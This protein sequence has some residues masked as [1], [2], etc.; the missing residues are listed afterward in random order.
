MINAAEGEVF[1]RINDREW[2]RATT[3]IELR[4]GDA[5]KTGPISRAELLLYPG[6]YLRLSENTEV[7]FTDTSVTNLKLRIVKGTAIIEVAVNDRWGYIESVY[8]LITVTT[9]KSE[10]AIL[11][12][13]IYRFSIEADGRGEVSVRKGRV[14]VE[15]ILVREGKKAVISGGPPGIQAYDRDENDRFDQ[16]SRERAKLLLQANKLMKEETWYEELSK[17]KKAIFVEERSNI[18]PQVKNQYVVSAKA[19]TVSHVEDASFKRDPEDWGALAVGYD[20]RG[21][22]EVKTDRGSRAEIH[23]SPDSYLRLSGETRI[24]FSDTSPERVSLA[25]SS[26]SAIIESLEDSE[27]DATVRIGTPYGECSVAGGGVYRFNIDPAGQSEVLVRRGQARIAGLTAKEG[28]KVILNGSSPKVIEF[29]REAQDSFD[30]W[31]KYRADLLTLPGRKQG[32]IKVA[33]N[34]NRPWYCG[35]WFYSGAMNCFT[36]VPGLWDFHTPYGG[37]YS[38]KFVNTRLR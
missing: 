8:T 11:P 30:V 13:G 7:V 35:L 2:R 16:W 37:G 5:L 10:Y 33:Y 19:G 20:L 14:V 36:F 28:K 38:I 9:S 27:G 29:N 3:R 31:S 26:G 34:V 1:A 23:L 24:K 22:D 18:Q 17:G 15:G 21:G 12:G 4:S 6:S 32:F 25:L